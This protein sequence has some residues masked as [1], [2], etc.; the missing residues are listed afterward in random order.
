MALKF[1]NSIARFLITSRKFSPGNIGIR[2]TSIFLIS[3]NLS[4]WSRKKFRSGKNRNS[5]NKVFWTILTVRKIN[6]RKFWKSWH[7]K[8]KVW[9]KRS[10]SHSL[11]P[12]SSSK[13][14][15]SRRISTTMEIKKKN[16]NK[17]RKKKWNRKWKKRNKKSVRKVKMIWTFWSKIW[18][19]AKN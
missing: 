18:K 3:R 6:I 12:N 13:L 1:I 11:W 7:M 8:K 2:A 15:K 5:A 10:A 16:Q 17:N 9:K 4:N 19:V 14:K